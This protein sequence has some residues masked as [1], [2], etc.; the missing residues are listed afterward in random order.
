MSD[1]LTKLLGVRY[2]VIQGGMAWVSDACLAAAVSNAGGLGVIAGGS[3]DA[4]TVRAEIRR[5]RTLCDRPFGLNIMLMSDHA[6]DLARLA[7]EEK[8]PVVIT[9]AG[10]PSRFMG[11]WKEAGLLILPVVPSA[12]LARRMEKLGADAIIAEGGESG[13]HIGEMNTMAL[14]PQVADAV[15]IPVVAAGGVAD[16]RGLAAALMLGADGVQC[17]T[18]FL[19]ADECGIHD[20]YKDMIIA[21]RD[22]GTVVTGRSGQGHP[23]RQLKN[24]MTRRFL[25]MEKRGASERELEEFVLGSLRLATQQGDREHGSFMA[26]Q[27][28]GLVKGRAGAKEIIEGM[29]QQARLLLGE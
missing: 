16:G 20:N 25:E 18:C 7:I 22:T 29:V 13:G 23:V 19:V 12:S 8:V 28:A 5:L 4:D 9:G 2:P 27:I 10:S 26:G 17:G 21:A 15:D 1:R 11:G 6:G 3:A 14:I 24:P